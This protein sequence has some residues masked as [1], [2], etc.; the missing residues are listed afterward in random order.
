MMNVLN[1]AAAH[2]AKYLESL[3]ERPIAPQVPLAELQRRLA[4]PLPEQGVADEAVIDELVRDCDGGLMGSAGGRFFGWVIGGTLPAALAA[5]WLT[6]TW[7]QN[8]AS[9]VTAPAE[10]VVEQVCG[11]WIKQLLGLPDSA[12]F[13]LVTGCQMAHTTAL[14]SAR[15]KLLR[16][17]G[18]DVEARGVSGAPPIRILTTE[19]RH[20][21]ILRAARV[22][23]IGTDAVKYVRADNL[24]RIDVGALETALKESGGGPTVVLLQAG[25]L[26]TGMFD[27]FGPACEAAHAAKAWVHVDGA[28]GL[29]V[30]ASARYRS[31]LDG[32]ERADSWATDGHK[33]L[34]LP[35]D[36][37]LVF[38]RDAAAH[39][40]SF[41][42][43]TS[44]SVPVEAVRNQKDW[45]PEWSRRGR[46]FPL[47]TALRS[48]GRA[49]IADMVERC[50]AHATRLV[51]E[52]GALPGAE[53]ASMPVINQGL[54]RFS[55]KTGEHDT[56][57]DRVIRRIQDAGVA[58]F[59]GSTWRGMRVMRISVCN[60]RTTGDD[61][62]ATIASVAEALAAER[63]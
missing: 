28:I 61:V 2:A 5:D 26:N 44:Y 9:N 29:W 21:S 45:N 30:G 49:G 32:V 8:A 7:D 33:W 11:E 53:I 16:D 12:S 51:S 20:E 31:L 47:Y 40:A 43:D 19:N 36:S 23:G 58:F 52:I 35:F 18:W 10:A 4:K 6:S 42:Q 13:A 14:A 3:P 27:P 1:V 15:H 63:G 17:R 41:A 46:G 24:G 48:L 56:F 38:V 62:T 25:D 39:K 22:L 57:T 54:V 60:W 55:S 50:S 34:N 59:G 37:G